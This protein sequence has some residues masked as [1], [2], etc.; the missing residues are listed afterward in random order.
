[1]FF[2]TPKA[3][4]RKIVAALSLSIPATPSRGTPSGGSRR[5]SLANRVNKRDSR[6]FLRRKTMLLSTPGAGPSGEKVWE[7]GFHERTPGVDHTQLEP[8]ELEASEPAAGPSTPM[9]QDHEDIAVD[10]D[11][12]RLDAFPSWDNTHTSDEYEEEEEDKENT[13]VPEEWYGDEEDEDEYIPAPP[14]GIPM[15]IGF[16]ADQF[17]LGETLLQQC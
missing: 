4:E 2:G 6:E 12:L 16:C 1:M 7:G 10:L 3:V 9:V 17:E 13:A 15:T 11:S 8:V 14:E 5:S